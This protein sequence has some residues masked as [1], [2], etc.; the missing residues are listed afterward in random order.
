MSPKDEN[1]RQEISKPRRSTWQ[2]YRILFLRLGFVLVLPLLVIVMPVWGG[3][4]VPVWMDLAGILLI[5]A[6]VL[7]R[8]W[9]ILYVG[10]RKD[11]TVVQEGPYSICRHPLYLF[12]TIATAG[13]GL[14]LGSVTLALLLS[15]GAFYILS[16]TAAGEEVVLRKMYGSAYDDYAAQTPRILPAIGQ[17]RTGPRIDV[18][19]HELRNNFLDAVVF[20]TFIP[21]ARIIIWARDAYGLGMFPLP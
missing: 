16:R 1:P 7:G 10:G 12:S 3:G 11:K 6:G 5:V 14:M 2:N 9:A 18:D 21:L 19:V 20:I 13:L 4:R 15:G 17:F 8:F